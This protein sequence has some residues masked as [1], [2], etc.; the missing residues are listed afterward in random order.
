MTA[1][2]ASVNA[3]LCHCF[4]QCKAPTRPRRLDPST[5][6]R[7]CLKQWHTD[8]RPG[9][10]PVQRPRRATL[11]LA[12]ILPLIVAADPISPQPDSSNLRA[13]FER[14]VADF[15]AAVAI[16]DHGGPR[17]QAIYRRAADGFS[18]LVDAGVEN[19]HLY[20]NLANAQLRLGETGPA[21]V[22][23]RRA[24]RLMPGDENVRR[25]LQFARNLCEVRIERQ[26]VG[27]ALETLFF[28]H[29]GTSNRSRSQAA[30]SG[31]AA[32]WFLMIVGLLIR[33][34]LPPL[35]WTTRAVGLLALVLACSVGWGRL[36]AHRKEG[37][38]V[39]DNVVLRKGNGP[40]YD[41]Q[42]EA[43][44]AQGVEFRLVETR[45]DV[46]GHIWY[47]VEL[48]DGTDGWLPGDQ[49]DLI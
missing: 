21:I 18:A 43:P 9:P 27:S 26:A 2:P 44:L 17:A 10:P 23:Y 48:P 45:E 32:F 34:R 12:A 35:L 25:N 42:L 14:T 4:K 46:D 28:W 47:Y 13:L 8:R 40:S 7:H 3:H 6:L 36:A 38:L 31:Y 19:G 33:R 15:E 20:Y 11:G 49:A 5:R 22:N 37:V 29:H 30:L 41:P 39:A 16:E 1:P 24:L